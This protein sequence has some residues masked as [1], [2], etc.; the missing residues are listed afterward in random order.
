MRAA[1][2]DVFRAIG[3]V[4]RAIFFDVHLVGDLEVRLA[5][6]DRVRL[7]VRFVVRNQ[8]G[9]RLQWRRGAE[10]VEPLVEVAL[11]AV[12]QVDRAVLVLAAPLVDARALAPQHEVV[13]RVLVDDA[14]DVGGIDDDRALL[15]QHGNR[16]FHRLLLLVVEPTARGARL[17]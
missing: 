8:V 2:R 9:E 3:L 5:V 15:L 6:L 12:L 17:P 4:A 10:R 7:H 1:E 14:R 16:L 11:H 13:L